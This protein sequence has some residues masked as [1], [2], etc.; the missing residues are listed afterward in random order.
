MKLISLAFICLLAF[1]LP[2]L[3]ASPVNNIDEDP[4]LRTWLFVGPFD[5]FEKAKL[6][7]DSLSSFSSEEIIKY[8]KSNNELDEFL[9]T[10]KANIGDHS[11]F[12]YFPNDNGKYVIGFSTI[13]SQ[14]DTELFYNHFVNNW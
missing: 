13:F 1:L 14:N 8:C 10:S 9:I 4:F 3:N 12:Q 5:D 2:Q 7:S 11:I 6:I